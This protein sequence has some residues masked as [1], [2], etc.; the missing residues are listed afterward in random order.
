MRNLMRGIVLSGLAATA[1]LAIGAGPALATAGTPVTC[2]KTATHHCTTHTTGMPGKT[3]AKGHHG[4][5]TGMHGK[6]HHGH[7]ASMHGKT[8]HGHA[9]SMHGKTHHSTAVKPAAPVTKPVAPPA[10]PAG[11]APK[12]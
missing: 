12:K 9:A 4:H 8:H 5:V 10:K 6:T 2:Q 1:G 3:H 11:N 7:A